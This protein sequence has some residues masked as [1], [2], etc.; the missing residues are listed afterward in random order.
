MPNPTDG[1]DPSST[2]KEFEI[3]NLESEIHGVESR[4]QNCLGLPYMGRRR[5]NPYNIEDITWPRRDM[6]FIF[7][8]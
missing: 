8:C 6:N 2:D 7:E 3:Q 4:I 1:W 5:V